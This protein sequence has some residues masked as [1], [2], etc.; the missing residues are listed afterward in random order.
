VDGH[1]TSW[2]HRPQVF[3]GLRDL[4]PRRSSRRGEHV[5]RLAG[6]EQRVAGMH[7]PR[8]VRAVADEIRN[9]VDHRDFR[10]Y[11]GMPPADAAHGQVSDAELVADVHR[12]PRAAELLGRLR[13]GVQGGLRVGI[14]QCREPLRVG[15]VGMLMGD[16]DRRQA[17]DA[18]ESVREVPGIEQH[19]RFLTGIALEIRE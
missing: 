3:D 7:Q 11:H 13:V 9:V 15:V 4:H 12:L 17:G 10:V 14:D 6:R 5:D 2:R 19:R 16:Q 18:L 1:R 8:R